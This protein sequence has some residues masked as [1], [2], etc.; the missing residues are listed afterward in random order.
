V[1]DTSTTR[2]RGQRMRGIVELVRRQ[3]A[4]TVAALAEGFGV[5]EM[6]IRRDLHLLHERGELERTHGGAVAS[7]RTVPE[8]PWMQRLGEQAAAKRA[9]GV[10][11]AGSIPD[12]STIFLGSGTTTLAVAD[13]LR[14]R[15]D[16]T[17][18]TNALPI[19]TALAGTAVDALVVGGFLRHRE[20]SL[21]GHL[22]E[23]ALANLRCDEVV[24]GMRGVHP[25]HGLTSE[26]LPEL[27]TDQAIM[28][29][30]DRLTVVADGS[31][32][33]NVAT[34]RTAA[35][36]AATRVVTDASAPPGVV[37]AIRERGVP[38]EVVEHP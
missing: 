7:H 8:P 35:V 26:H 21:I 18:M 17:V 20:M 19:A 27:E 29:T 11:V 33:G 3:G 25:E 10:A 16:L 30:A 24:M 34:S 2:L 9:I 32:L 38:V 5:S 4:V 15:C 23:E 14:S 22:A 6:T 28:R 13:E 36:E 37:E 31:K 1:T 12:G